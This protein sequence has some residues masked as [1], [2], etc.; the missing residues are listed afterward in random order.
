MS[1]AAAA[2]GMVLL[3]AGESRRL[4]RPKQLLNTGDKTLVARQ[5]EL[6]LAL[7]PACVVVVTGAEQTAVSEALHGLQV[8][9]VHNANWR[10]GMGRSI[11]CGVMAMPERVRACLLVLVDQWQLEPADLQMLI[12]AWQE[13]PQSAVTAQWTACGGE[14][15]SGPP[16]IFPRSLF[17]R[18][19]RLSGEHGA[20]GV[21]KR[22]AARLRRVELP[23]AA[24]DL[25]QL[26]DWPETWPRT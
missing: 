14:T 24:A 17:A 12:A 1:E 19:G 9:Q 23:H 21:L 4:G 10:D 3:A 18:L 5:A 22:H 8:Q 6:L 2:L 25:D 16:V 26:E 20:R 7:Q 15:A 11:A 13:D